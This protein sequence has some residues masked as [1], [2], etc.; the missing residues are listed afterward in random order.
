MLGSLPAAWEATWAKAWRQWVRGFGVHLLS[1]P[2]PFLNGYGHFTGQPP[3]L[4]PGPRETHP[5]GHK[6]LCQV[7]SAV[8][9]FKASGPL[10]TELLRN[11]HINHQAQ[12]AGGAVL[13]VGTAFEQLDLNLDFAPCRLRDLQQALS[14]SFLMSKFAW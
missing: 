4:P 5:Y 6:G 13:G 7:A 3:P 2:W 1:L 10:G 9:F 14:F 11:H 8:W 12:W